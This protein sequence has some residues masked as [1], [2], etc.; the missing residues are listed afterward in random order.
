MGWSVPT[1][2]EKLACELGKD[3][4]DVRLPSGSA[5]SHLHNKHDRVI[6]YDIEKDNQEPVI[7]SKR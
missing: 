7:V 2:S 4:A 5:A 1:G 3:Y 6:E